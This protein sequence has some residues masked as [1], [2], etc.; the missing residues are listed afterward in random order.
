M[1]GFQNEQNMSLN[2]ISNPSVDPASVSKQGLLLKSL[3]DYYNSDVKNAQKLVDA[4]EGKSKLSLRLI[5]WGCT[6]YSKHHAPEVYNNYRLQLKSF[7]K[8]NFD[9]FKRRERETLELTCINKKLVTTTA[10]MAFFKWYH[11]TG[12]ASFITENKEA[13]EQ[14]MFTCHAMRTCRRRKRSRSQSDS[15][16]PSENKKRSGLGDA[17]EVASSAKRSTFTHKLSTKPTISRFKCTVRFL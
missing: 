13:I 9:P 11:E 5:D 1:H 17:F 8:R 16:T 3:K 12:I 2:E 15:L 7:S 10:Q 14:D 6:N 4:L